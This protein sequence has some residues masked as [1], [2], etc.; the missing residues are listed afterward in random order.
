MRFNILESF[1]VLESLRVNGLSFPH[2][3]NEDNLLLFSIGEQYF[4]KIFITFIA[5]FDGLNKFST[6]LK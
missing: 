3:N 6:L 1:N 2:L 4:V 5:D